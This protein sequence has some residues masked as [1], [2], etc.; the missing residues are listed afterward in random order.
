MQYIFN[1]GGIGDMLELVLKRDG[2]LYPNMHIISNMM[3]FDDDDV[4]IGF[5]EPLVHM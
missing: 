4:I 1:V 3:I 5:K 2:V